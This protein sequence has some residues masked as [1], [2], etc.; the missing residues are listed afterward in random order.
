L[1]GAARSSVDE[2][3]RRHADCLLE[4]GSLE[5]APTVIKK[6]RD[7]WPEA[8]LFAATR[9]A[10]L[11]RRRSRPLRPREFHERPDDLT[12]GRSECVNVSLSQIRNGYQIAASAGEALLAKLDS[13][14]VG[15]HPRE[16]TIAVRE[17]MNPC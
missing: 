15:R 5:N 2:T 12:I 16:T 3:P 13:Q 4:A 6:A 17:W 14:Q 9:P 7:R 10:L 8:E 1:A 11:V